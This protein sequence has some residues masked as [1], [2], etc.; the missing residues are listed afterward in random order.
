MEMISKDAGRSYDEFEVA[1]WM[2]LRVL[3]LLNAMLGIKSAL[4]T[5]E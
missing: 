5:V 3:L 1:I 4:Q 2:G